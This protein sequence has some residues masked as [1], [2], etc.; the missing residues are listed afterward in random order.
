[1]L[2]DMEVAPPSHGADL[3]PDRLGGP[4]VVH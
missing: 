4:R 3:T 1:V 2:D